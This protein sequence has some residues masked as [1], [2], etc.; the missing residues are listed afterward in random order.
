M[1]RERRTSVVSVVFRYEAGEPVDCK[2]L[3]LSDVNVSHGVIDIIV[4]LFSVQ[5]SQQI[6]NSHL[7]YLLTYHS[8]LTQVR[9]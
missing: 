5:Q 8:Y 2:F 7:S 6:N 3:D 1:E 4:F 9:F